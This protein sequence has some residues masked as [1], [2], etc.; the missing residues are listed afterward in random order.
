MSSRPHS[1][2]GAGTAR[3][4]VIV[5]RRADPLRE[6]RQ[7]KAARCGWIVRRGWTRGGARARIEG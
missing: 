1:E 4:G 3:S 7:L 5:G 2:P 6:R